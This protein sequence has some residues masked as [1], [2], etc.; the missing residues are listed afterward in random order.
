M[1][2]VKVK[3]ALA[4]D[5]EGRWAVAG[6]SDA[7]LDDLHSFA[8]DHI[9]TGEARY[10]LTADV[11]IPETNELEAMLTPHESEGK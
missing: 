2:T 9:S 11:P 1:K 3:I 4:I 5:P 7:D 6:W 8:I 10:W